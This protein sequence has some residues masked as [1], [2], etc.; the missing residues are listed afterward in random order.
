M[1]DALLGWAM[2]LGMLVCDLLIL[3]A[4]CAQLGSSDDARKRPALT[5]GAIRSPTAP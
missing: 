1:A 5:G 4:G 2:I 3:E